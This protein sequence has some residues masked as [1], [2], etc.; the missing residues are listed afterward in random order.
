MSM[1]GL[2]SGGSVSIFNSKGVEI[3]TRNIPANKEISWNG[4]NRNHSKVASG[5]YY[6][7][8]KNSKGETVSKRPIMIVN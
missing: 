5:V 8:V 3:Y 4:E 1:N 6:V 2:P 7:L